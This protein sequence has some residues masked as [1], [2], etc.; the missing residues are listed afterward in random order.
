MRGDM[1]QDTEKRRKQEKILA[2]VKDLSIEFTD[3][4]IYEE[5]V[6]KISFPIYEGEILGVVGES[7]SGKSMSAL[8]IMGLLPDSAQVKSGSIEFCK[9]D[10]NTV[11]LLQLSGQEREKIQGEEI[12]MV[13]QEPMTSLNPVMKI[14]KQVGEN[15]ALHTDLSKEEIHEK[16]VKALQAVGLSEA[17]ALLDRYPHE[18]SGGMRQRVMIAIALACEPK[19]LIADEPTTALDVTIQAQILEL[20][21]DLKE[22]LGMAIIMITHDLGIVA[23]MCEKIAVMYAGKIVEYGTTDEIFYEPKHEYTKGLLRSIPRLDSKDHERLVPIEG[24]PVDMLNP[25]KG[26]PFAPRCGACMKVCLREMP[27]RTDFSDTHYTQCWLCQKAEFEAA[28][29][30]NV[31]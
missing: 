19:L 31:Q 4:G 28:Q 27:P 7:G 10:G 22:K 29:G 15:L 21:M 26:C 30:G 24:T 16:C 9:K 18:L 23:R 13:F 20:M 12:A 25:P 1:G 6:K 2:S 8:S 17:E 11:D 3:R 14:G 5:V